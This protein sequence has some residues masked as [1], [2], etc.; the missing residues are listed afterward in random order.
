[1]SWSQALLTLLLALLV[2]SAG[3]VIGWHSRGRNRRTRRLRRGPDPKCDRVGPYQHWP[4]G[5][6]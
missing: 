4:M 1:M 6:P 3:Y 2:Y 5:R